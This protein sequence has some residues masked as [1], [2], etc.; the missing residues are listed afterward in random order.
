MDFSL[1]HSTFFLIFWGVFRSHFHLIPPKLHLRAEEHGVV[2]LHPFH[3]NIWGYLVFSPLS[4]FPLKHYNRV[5]IQLR[6]R[7]V[8]LTRRKILLAGG[9]VNK[10]TSSDA[11]GPRLQSQELLFNGATHLYFLKEIATTCHWSCSLN[12][13][14]LVHQHQTNESQSS[15][16]LLFLLTSLYFLW[17]FQVGFWPSTGIYKDIS[18]WDENIYCERNRNKIWVSIWAFIVMYVL[19]T[20]IT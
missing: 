20:W 2:S 14:V 5:L 3:H 18:K 16:F 11:A 17:I 12:E 7:M 6:Q 19:L 9:P 10:S 4:H 13:S 8:H 1:H 15:R